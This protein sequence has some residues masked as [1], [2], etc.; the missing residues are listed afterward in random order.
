M[1]IFKGTTGPDRIDLRADSQVSWIDAAE[2]D[3][4]VYLSNNLAYETG[5]GADTVF[6][7]GASALMI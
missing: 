3:D 7:G 6:G 4:L 5:P 1:T 2:G